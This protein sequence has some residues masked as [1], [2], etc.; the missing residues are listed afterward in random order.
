M[1]ARVQL[2][3]V[4][5]LFPS[6]IGIF[7]GMVSF[8]ERCTSLLSSFKEV[9][10][11]SL[12]FRNRDSGSIAEENLN[13]MMALTEGR[14]RVVDIDL[15]SP[16][17]AADEFSAILS[18]NIFRECIGEIFL[19]ATTFTH[20]QL[21]IL[22]RIFEV[23]KVKKRIFVGYTGAAVYSFNTTVEHAWL[24]RGVSHIRSVL[25]Y[26][27]SL[28]PSKRLHLII[29]V[30]FEHERAAAMIE[31]FEP[32]KLTLGVGDLHQSV[33]TSLHA[34]NQRFFNELKGFIERTRM[35]FDSVETFTF[36]CIDPILTRNA[37]LDQASAGTDFNIVVCPMNT[38]LS[39][40]GAGLA[41]LKDE[42]IQ[43]A[44]ARAIEYN[45]TGY[46]SPSGEATIYELSFS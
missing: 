24:S 35:T 43:L 33:S 29:L 38:K 17:T 20:E 30:G 46:S 40:I 44:Y 25:G 3:Q 14:H 12:I 21:L 31:R 5:T 41:A 36:S 4:S 34:T 39:T 18:G 2:Q 26:P 27:G 9:P 13:K 8:E 15:N 19:D 45:E 28:A 16:I 6:G 7:I 11:H 1:M 32:A 37:V 22:L 42:R 10:A 23:A